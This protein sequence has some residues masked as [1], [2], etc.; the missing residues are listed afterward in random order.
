MVAVNYFKQL[1]FYTRTEK[2][3]DL[4]GLIGTLGGLGFV[5]YGLFFYSKEKH[6]TSK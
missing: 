6:N 1:I 3:L 5:I 4:F 2:P